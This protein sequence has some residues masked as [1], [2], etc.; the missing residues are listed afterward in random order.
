[1][2]ANHNTVG[3]EWEFYTTVSDTSKINRLPTRD[4][5]KSQL[6]VGKAKVMFNYKYG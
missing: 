3:D 4:E 5:S 2:K 6:V 1:M